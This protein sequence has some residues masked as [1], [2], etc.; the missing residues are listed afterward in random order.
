MTGD[1]RGIE[2]DIVVALS[3]LVEL[4]YS[5]VSH[6]RCSVS[7]TWYSYILRKL[8]DAA[9][10]GNNTTDPTENLHLNAPG[11]RCTRDGA[12]RLI[13]HV[14]ECL[15]EVKAGTQPRRESE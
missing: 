10:D 13:A 11:R 12:L 14:I 3:D 1:E 4:G 8:R 5:I 7:W 15:A 9:D 2:R 6:V